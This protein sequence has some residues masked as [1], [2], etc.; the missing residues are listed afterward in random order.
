[1]YKTDLKGDQNGSLNSP[2]N[3]KKFKNKKKNFV[4]SNTKFWKSQNQNAPGKLGHDP[5][6]TK[7]TGPETNWKSTL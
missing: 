1:L 2:E 7:G 6:G 3:G 4:P 5:R